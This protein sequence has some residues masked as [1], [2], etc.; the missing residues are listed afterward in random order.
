[1]NIEE[2]N[3][4][5]GDKGGIGALSE[6][7]SNLETL[8]KIRLHFGVSRERIR[9]WMKEIF[10]EKYDP[11][12]PRRERRINHIIDSIRKN[13]VDM[14]KEMMPGINKWYLKTAIET[15]KHETN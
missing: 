14:T 9:Q 6:M 12:K 11:R 15:L 13:G 8:E 7:R 1:M 10:G 3:K 2:F 4:R 5:Y